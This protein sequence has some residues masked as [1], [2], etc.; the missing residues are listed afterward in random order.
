MMDN[1]KIYLTNLIIDRIALKPLDLE[2]KIER[3]CDKIRLWN[4]M[5]SGSKL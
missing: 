4:G 3:L 2:S 5:L 1:P